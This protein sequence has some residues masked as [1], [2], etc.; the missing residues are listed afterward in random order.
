[1]TISRRIPRPIF[2]VALAGVLA[3]SSLGAFAAQQTELTASPLAETAPS[4]SE[5]TI[6]PQAEPAGES[7]LDDGQLF[8]TY[9]CS[10]TR[11]CELRAC[12]VGPSG[13]YWARAD[14]LLWWTRGARVT[15]LVT[16]SDVTDGGIIGQPTT[17]ILFGNERVN[18][19][20]RSN[21]RF[22]FG[23]WLHCGR[24]LGVE[25]DYFTLGDAHTDFRFASSESGYPLYARPFY[26]VN[27]Q[28]TG[29]NAELVS[30]PEWLRG[31]IDGRVDEYF[32]S[33]GVN[34]RLNLCCHQPCCGCGCEEDVCGDCCDDVCDDYCDD[35]CE[36]SC[37]TELRGTRAAAYCR[38]ARS[39]C[40]KLNQTCYRVDLIAGY[41]HY[42]LNDSLQVNEDL[43]AFEN[44]ELI[45]AGTTFEIT[46][47]FRSRNE[48]HGGELGLVAQIYRG[49]WSLDLLAKMAIGNNHQ[50]VRIN[51]QTTVQAPDDD[52]VTY[53]AG[54]LAL[55]TNDGRHANDDFVVI[56]QFGA[57][58]GYQ[59]TCRLR[60]FVGY[61]F[62]YWANVARASEQ[63]D[64]TLNSSYF[65]PEVPAGDPRPEFVWRDS[66]FWA[67]GMNFGLEYRF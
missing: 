17:E 26:D 8:S 22:N 24:T 65:P 36:S 3:W 40:D 66:D 33:A 44:H 49:C 39:L 29:Q 6:V 28:T 50:V 52:P 61:N 15:P 53:D 58:L 13:M 41:R 9:Q 2:F 4:A 43:V 63:V 38:G 42:R 14:Y 60:A 62:I 34:A 7:L 5:G 55:D 30:T 59:M 48:F 21:V 45:D 23:W 1:M 32:H 64:Y 25:F 27:P 18:G 11:E 35:G 10:P 20:S 57:E 12:L 19:D 47:R 37:L 46:D 54:I 16:T 31:T 67:Q 51:G 56:P